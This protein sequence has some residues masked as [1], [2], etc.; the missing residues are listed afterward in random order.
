MY[1]NVRLFIVCIDVK[2]DQISIELL[3]DLIKGLFDELS[4]FLFLSHVDEF[5]AEVIELGPSHRS[6]LHLLHLLFSDEDI[7]NTIGNLNNLF[8]GTWTSALLKQH[9]SK[10]INKFFIKLIF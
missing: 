7:G 8:K 6:Q 3:K 1:L 9:I 10:V 4:D 2:N 5:V